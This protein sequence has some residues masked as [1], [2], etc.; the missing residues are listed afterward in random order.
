MLDPAEVVGSSL[1]NADLNRDGYAN[2]AIGDRSEKVIG[3]TGRERRYTEWF[4]HL[5]QRQQK[6][7]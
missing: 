4:V 7:T 2:L 3:K 1:A 6:E 5:K